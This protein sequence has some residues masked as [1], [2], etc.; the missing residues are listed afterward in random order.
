MPDRYP[1]TTAPLYVAPGMTSMGLDVDGLRSAVVTELEKIENVLPAF[2]RISVNTIVN[3]WIPGP[4]LSLATSGT[5]PASETRQ[6]VTPVV[7]YG[8]A[9]DRTGS[10][11]TYVQVPGRYRLSLVFGSDAPGGGVIR[12][13][14]T[15]TYATAAQPGSLTVGGPATGSVVASPLLEVYLPNACV[16]SVTVRRNAGVAPD[17]GTAAAYVLGLLLERIGE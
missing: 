15:Y 8:A 14:V 1:S 3:L 12:W 10:A 7:T 17:T 5:A 6:S 4:L 11:S 13:T 9:V 16:F 2:P